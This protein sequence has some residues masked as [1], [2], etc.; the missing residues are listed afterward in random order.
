MFINFM[1]NLNSV[2]KSNVE[3]QVMFFFY[4][5][6]DNKRIHSNIAITMQYWFC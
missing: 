2:K 3:T 6:F 1:K 5:K 4:I